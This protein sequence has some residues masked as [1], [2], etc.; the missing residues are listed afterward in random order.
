MLADGG[1]TVRGR[2]LELKVDRMDR[3]GLTRGGGQHAKSLE[4]QLPRDMSAPLLLQVVDLGLSHACSAVTRLPVMGE[5]IPEGR[6]WQG[7]AKTP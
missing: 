6:K 5:R 4:A 2:V 1:R 7:V 3:L